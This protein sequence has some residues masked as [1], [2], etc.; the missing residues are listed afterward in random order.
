MNI[1]IRLVRLFAMC[2]L[3]AP[4]VG[5][6][7]ASLPGEGD[8]ETCMA[9]NPS[10]EM[11]PGLQN[12]PISGW[13]DEGNAGFGS[14]LVTH[15]QRAAWLF[16]PFTGNTGTSRLYDLV[17]SSPG[18]RHS[19]SIDVGHLGTDRLIG[20]ARA[21]LVVAWLDDSG[22]EVA[23]QAVTLLTADDITDEPITRS[24][25]LD[26]AP[27]GTARMRVELV[28]YQSD[29]QETGRAWFDNLRL[30]RSVPSVY[31]WADFGN[32]RLDFAGYEWRVKNVY[33]GPGPNL[34]SASED[35]ADIEADGSLKLGI[36]YG[37]GVWRC[38]EV[39]LEDA[40]GYG[41]YR[42]KTRGR[43]DLLDRNVVFGLFLWEYPQCYRPD[44]NWWNP[45]SEFDIEFS[46]W[47]NPDPDYATGQF[48]AQPYDWNGNISRFDT[49]RDQNG[50]LITSE[51]T[52]YAD[53]MECRAWT[54]HGDAPT[55]ETI[56]H[57]W[58]Y[59]RP[60]LPRPGAPRVHLNMWLLNGQAPTDGQDSFV[61][62]D[63]FTFIAEA[64][65]AIPCPGDF[66]GDGAVDGGDLGELLGG[67]GTDGDSDL[68]DDGNIDGGDIGI[69]LSVWGACPIEGRI[70][71]EP[72]VR[73]AG[74][75]T[76]LQKP[77]RKDPAT[78]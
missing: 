56:L 76:T 18:W 34:F 43:M 8:V 13:T 58:T 53:R 22:S 70:A 49:P 28:F 7:A 39:T 25:V 32:R 37:D 24:G 60:H 69:L 72:K 74:L 26:P 57:E 14:S 55:P 31:Q 5:S 50:L 15:G 2:S 75:G 30:V 64:P 40:L 71:A 73:G 10:F 63:D 65:P 35:V 23:Q 4:G 17:S 59:L 3:V 51:F 52:W 68:N 38:S 54:G 1:R 41:T 47:G 29:A 62:V 66:N 21:L 78:K 6:A 61:W 42:F 45:P 19:F 36:S 46:R 67:W 9:S 20:D 12:N 77:A 48:V 11:G 44:V 16:G 33:T 27:A